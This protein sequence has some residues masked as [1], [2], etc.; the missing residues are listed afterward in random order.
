MPRFRA[1][2]FDLDGTLID[3]YAA[4]TASVNHVLQHYGRPPMTEDKVRSL[5]GHG[6]EELMETIVPNVDPDEAAQIYREHHPSVMGSHTRLLPG[7]RR[8]IEDIARHRDQ[9]RRL[10][11]QAVLL[12]AITVEN[13]GHRTIL[14]CRYTAPTTSAWQNRTR[15]AVAALEKMGVPREEALYVGDMDVDIETGRNAGIETWVIPTGS[16][17]EATLRAAGAERIL[18]NMHAVIAEI[19]TRKSRAR[20]KLDYGSHGRHGT[21]ERYAHFG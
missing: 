17:D 20:G 6:L 21:C 11:E 9:A 2:L 15:D 16:S 1:V 13:P 18:P 10:F 5:V 8:G 4:I 3:S 14:R 7:R 12:H 19:I